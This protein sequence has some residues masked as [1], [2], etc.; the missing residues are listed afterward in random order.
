M[1]FSFVSRQ[2]LNKALQHAIVSCPSSCTFISS[3]IIVV[4]FAIF[5]V[6]ASKRLNK[7]PLNISKVGHVYF[8]RTLPDY[9]KITLT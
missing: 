9:T 7:L 5:M 4:I 1:A 2:P 6:G 3:I 8:F